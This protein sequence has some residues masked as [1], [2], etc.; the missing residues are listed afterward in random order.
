MPVRAPRT[1]VKQ[2]LRYHPLEA[3]NG[4]REI[5]ARGAQQDRPYCP[6]WQGDLIFQLIT[7][8]GYEN[9]LETGFGTGSTAIYML[10][11]TEAGGGAV[12]SLDWSARNFNAIGKDN[13]RGSGFAARHTLHERPS[14]EVMAEFLTAGS[15]FD[16]VFIDGWKTFDYL[17]Y[18]TFIVNRMMPKGGCLMFD[19]S[20]LPSVR[21][22]IGML[23]SHYLF[24]E[25]DYRRYGQGHRLRLRHVLTTRSPA[26]PYRAIIKTVNTEQ[27]PT[28]S[29]WRF[30]ARF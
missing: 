20:G 4:V 9:C 5:L 22:L 3:T 16:F 6:P 30:H 28:T 27:Q 25:I 18:E 13:V 26:R 12:T 8:N 15:R 24:E 17:A 7:R 29:D 1:W 23:K 14:F 10:A 19:D 11:A 2:R 21:Q